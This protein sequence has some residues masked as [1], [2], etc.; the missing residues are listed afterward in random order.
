MLEAALHL[1]T[2]KALREDGPLPFLGQPFRETAV[3]QQLAQ[4]LRQLARLESDR[5]RQIESS[6]DRPRHRQLPRE[7]E[8]AASPNS[9]R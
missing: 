8:P 7:P 2:T 9:C 3:R 5:A 4:A 6:V 1:L